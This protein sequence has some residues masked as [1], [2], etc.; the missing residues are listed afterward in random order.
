MTKKEIQ[1][2]IDSIIDV[3]D[4]DEVAHCEED[5]LRKDFIEYIAKRKDSLGKKARLIL[6]TNELNFARWCA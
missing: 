2:R 1:R 3:I 5:D 6:T 4:D